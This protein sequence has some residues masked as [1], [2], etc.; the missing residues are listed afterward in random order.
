MKFDGELMAFQRTSSANRVAIA[1]WGTTPIVRP[2]SAQLKLAVAMIGSSIKMT[3]RHMSQIWRIW[4]PL[5]STD[6]SSKP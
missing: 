6:D 5:R 1:N 2:H 3:A 4:K